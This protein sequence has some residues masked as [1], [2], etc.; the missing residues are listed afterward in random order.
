MN[1]T[2]NAFRNLVLAGWA[3]AVAGAA[4]AQDPLSVNAK[5]VRL[6]LDNAHVRVLE[7]TLQPGE[8][9]KPHSHPATVLY[10]IS[11]G[12]IRNHAAGGKVTESEV[13]AG[14]VVYR[15]P[16]THWAENVGTTPVHIV[17]VELKDARNDAAR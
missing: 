1:I 7:A 5:T 15:D 3:I 12:R 16:L 2:R 4:H 8:K 6:R 9:E 11:G 17:I 10:V 13:K 14:D